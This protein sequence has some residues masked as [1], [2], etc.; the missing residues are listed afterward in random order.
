[1]PIVRWKPTRGLEPRTPSLPCRARDSHLRQANPAYQAGLAR[2]SRCRAGAADATR[3]G[4]IPTVSAPNRGLGVKPPTGLARVRAPRR[5]A[6]LASSSNVSRW[7]ST[8]LRTRRRVSLRG[9]ASFRSTSSVVA[10]LRGGFACFVGIGFFVIGDCDVAVLVLWWLNK[11]R[12]AP[13][14]PKP[15]PRPIPRGAFSGPH[16]IACGTS[17]RP[18][19]GRSQIAGTRRYAETSTRVRADRTF[20]QFGE[21]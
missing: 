14:T 19:C 6:Y 10:K 13:T 18:D 8:I 12:S 16:G 15:A 17:T 9:S 11:P 5:R 7:R 21:Q 20:P 2:I 3:S 4:R 1:L